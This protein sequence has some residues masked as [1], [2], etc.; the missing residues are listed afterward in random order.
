MEV[1]SQ[2]MLF[3]DSSFHPADVSGVW[4][5]DW[6]VLDGPVN[7]IF[8]CPVEYIHFE[9]VNQSSPRDVHTWTY[10]RVGSISLGQ[11]GAAS[12]VCMG[13]SQNPAVAGAAE[14]FKR[15]RK[16][17][18]RK[19]GG[20]G[21]RRKTRERRTT[22]RWEER[23]HRCPLL[24][25]LLFSH[26]ASSLLPPA[27]A[28]CIAQSTENH[29]QKTLHWNGVKII[30]VEPWQGVPWPALVRS[31]VRSLQDSTKSLH[32]SMCGWTGPS[33]Y[34]PHGSLSWRCI[35]TSAASW[36]VAHHCTHLSAAGAG[37]LQ[38]L[39]KFPPTTWSAPP[40]PSASLCSFKQNSGRGEGL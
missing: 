23:G 15:F 38:K 14:A 37:A 32:G 33:G 19:M 5:I 2:H 17:S 16:H 1:V 24:L 11:A 9:V 29:A 3:P 30:D 8:F 6:F 36:S 26:L 31:H 40:L 35:W 10:F 27:T 20:R 25:L 7:S 39:I 12:R 13:L 18:A 34:S 28:R 4:F 22:D 21:K